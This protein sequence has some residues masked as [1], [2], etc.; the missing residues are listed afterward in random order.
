MNGRKTL[1]T[2]CLVIVIVGVFAF[3]GQSTSRSNSSQSS[4]TGQQSVK[5]IPEYVRYM[6]LF[7]HHH[8]NMKKA[9]ELE[10]QGKDGSKFHS[11]FKHRADL[12]D[13]D[14]LIL[15]Q[16]TSDCEQALAQ[17]DAKAQAVIDA[18]RSRYPVGDLPAGVNLPPPPPELATMQE[19]RN[20][21]ILRARDRLHAEFGDAKF[22]RFE[23][24][25]KSLGSSITDTN[26]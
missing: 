12:S 13:E 21:I 10:K 7:A 14:A 20:A 17:Q 5:E 26:N 9:A 2:I 23:T 18:F 16:V 15:D 8:F 3:V 22:N 24:F 11:M 25:V 19:E 4:V 1:L 6:F